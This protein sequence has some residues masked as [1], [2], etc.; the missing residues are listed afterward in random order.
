MDFIL[1]RTNL[2]EGNR[3]SFL[4]V[5]DNFLG[6]FAEQGIASGGIGV[7]PEG[8]VYSVNNPSDCNF[9]LTCSGS[10]RIV[11]E[12]TSYILE[13]DDMIFI[14]PRI[15][16]YKEPV[17]GEWKA[18]W[19]WLEPV[20]EWNFSMSGQP[21]VKK[22]SRTGQLENCVNMIIEEANKPQASAT[23][24]SILTDL[25][26][27]IVKKEIAFIKDDFIASCLDTLWTHVKSDLAKKW[28][29]PKMAKSVGFSPRHLTRINHEYLGCSPIRHLILLRMSRA[30]EY[31]SFTDYPVGYIAKELG[32]TFEGDFCAAFKKS[33][34]YSPKEYRNLN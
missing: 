28:T 9:L 29:L 13:Q 19:L 16:N 23:L 3:E 27:S 18:I 8:Y 6:I 4:P 24:V 5:R 22:F 15:T 20:E 32:Y 25:L 31:L 17:S 33:T 14:P 10:G 12:H 34:G 30:K 26:C 11:T 1:K 2:P 21:I 7:R